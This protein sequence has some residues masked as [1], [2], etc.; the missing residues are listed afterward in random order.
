M[1][2]LAGFRVCWACAHAVPL[3]VTLFVPELTVYFPFVRW[4]YVNLT[5]ISPNRLKCDNDCAARAVGDINEVASREIS[6]IQKPGL[7]SGG[8]M[9]SQGQGVATRVS[10]LKHTNS[11]EK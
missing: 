1:R 5:F 8:W 4:L 2:F 10:D 11:M 6:I 7:E 9:Q 3:Y